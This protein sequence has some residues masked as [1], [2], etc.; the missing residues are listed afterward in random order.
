MYNREIAY[1]AFIISSFDLDKMSFYVITY[2]LIET[3]CTVSGMEFLN[4]TI[5]IRYDYSGL[6]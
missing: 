6:S 3:V 5:L 2:V 1:T 4:I